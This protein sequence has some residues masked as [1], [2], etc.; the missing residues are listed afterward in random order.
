MDR[1]HTERQLAFIREYVIDFNGTQAAIRAGYAPKSARYS[2]TR[3]LR[4]P[5]IQGQIQA[6]IQRISEKADVTAT[7]VLEELARVA[8]ADLSRAVQIINGRVHLLDTDNLTQDL[9]AA[10]SEISETETGIRVKFHDK[11]KALELLG[12]YLKL[13]TDKQELTGA[14]G[15]PLVVVGPP[16]T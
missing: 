6:Q 2:A 15:G 5:L 16:P 1:Q 14:D 9:R 8:F 13:F 10:I 11:T 12:K 3:M 7:R 4:N